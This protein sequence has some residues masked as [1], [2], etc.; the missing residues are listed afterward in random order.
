MG[1]RAEDGGTDPSSDGGTL[2]GGPSSTGKYDDVD[3]AAADLHLEVEIEARRRERWIRQ[4]LHEESTLTGA[5]TA[6]T[7]QEVAV[8]LLTGDRVPG[9]LISVGSDVVELRRHHRST[10]VKVDAVTVLEVSQAIPAAGPPATGATMAEVLCDLV[11]HRE[12]VLLLLAGGTS[13]RGALLA[14][15]DIATVDTGEGG[16]T[17]YVPVTAIVSVSAPT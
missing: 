3:V 10:W 13:V 14:V 1:P 12:D 11:E 15:G 4:R 6:A 8:Q 7:G 16:R 2:H 9:R 5:L 17:A